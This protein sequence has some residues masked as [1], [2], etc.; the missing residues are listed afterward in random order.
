MIDLQAGYMTDLNWAICNGHVDLLI[1][2]TTN[3]KHS[4]VQNLYQI[5]ILHTGIAE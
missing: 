1:P 2:T 4:E 3:T 5:W